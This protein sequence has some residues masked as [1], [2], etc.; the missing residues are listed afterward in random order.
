[1]KFINRET[2]NANRKVLNVVD[3][4]YNPTTGDIAI[5]ILDFMIGW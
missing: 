3:L 5:S 4:T 2:Q 1:M